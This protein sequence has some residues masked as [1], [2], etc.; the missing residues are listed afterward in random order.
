MGKETS[1]A[2]LL[3]VTCKGQK[4]LRRFCQCFPFAVIG[5]IPDHSV[6]S[7]ASTRGSTAKTDLG[8]GLRGLDPL[9]N[10]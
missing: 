3:G 6:I 4:D 8:S 2:A 9:K 10:C 5:I 7:Y 1:F